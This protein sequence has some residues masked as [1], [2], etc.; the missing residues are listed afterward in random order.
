MIG[1][2]EKEISSFHPGSVEVII[3]VLLAVF[4]RFPRGA[5]KG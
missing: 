3:F 5:T 1:F 4:K 2:L